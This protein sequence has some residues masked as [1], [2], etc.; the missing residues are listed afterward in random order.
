MDRRLRVPTPE[1]A[2]KE[3]N[4]FFASVTE[5]RLSL[6]EAVKSMRR[7]SR[8]TQPEFAKHRGIGLRALREIES[9]VGNPT[10]ETLNKVASIFGLEVGFVARR[11]PGS[12]GQPS[13]SASRGHI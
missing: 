9:G 10:V 2:L 6:A 3:R 11:R 8:L 13:A 12:A 4:A 5:G 7:L 1:E